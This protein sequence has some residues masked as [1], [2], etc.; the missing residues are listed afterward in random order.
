MKYGCLISFWLSA[1]LVAV[2]VLVS[3]CAQMPSVQNCDR[4]RYERIGLDVKIEAQCRVPL[5]MG[6]SL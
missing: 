6:V 5:G 4:V 2:V 3:G 1:A